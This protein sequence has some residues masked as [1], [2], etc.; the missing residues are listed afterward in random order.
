MY[1]YFYYIAQGLSVEYRQIVI[2]GYTNAISVGAFHKRM[3]MTPYSLC[4]GE[5]GKKY[6]SKA[7]NFSYRVYSWGNWE[8]EMIVQK[9]MATIHKDDDIGEILK[10]F[11]KVVVGEPIDLMDFYKEIGYE[12]KT[13]KI[14]GKTIRQW[15]ISEIKKAE[16]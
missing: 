13:K 3:L 15:I 9:H 11:E 6:G 10:E 16:K 12:Y 14:H 4:Y 2:T 8:E 1:P 7:Y 5:G